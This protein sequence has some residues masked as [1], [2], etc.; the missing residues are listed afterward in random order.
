MRKLAKVLPFF[1]FFGGMA[2]L[3][4][5]TPAP[6]P[7]PVMSTSDMLKHAAD[8]RVQIDGDKR[9]ILYLKEQTKKMKDVIKLSCV[10]DKLVQV[11]AEMNIADSTNDQLQVAISKNSDDRQTLYGQLSDIGATVKRLREEATA[12][13][14]EPEL[15]KQEARTTVDHP[16]I[17]DDPTGYNPFPGELDPPGYASPYH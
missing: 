2:V 4:A 1:A 14:G 3:R 11:N 13:V 7:A 16:E 12:C 5:D 15:Y 17:I 9:K 8:I 10:N 6:A